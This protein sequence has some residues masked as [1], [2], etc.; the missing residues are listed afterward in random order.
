ME[1]QMPTLSNEIA[2]AASADDV[3]G[4][5]GDLRATPEWI[6]GVVEAE[7][8][9]RDRFCRTADGGEIRERITD[10]SDEQRSFSYEQRRVPLPIS[11]SKGTLRVVEDGDGSRVEWEAEFEAPAEVAAMVDGYYRQTLEALK[12][13]VETGARPG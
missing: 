2:I 10:R 4:I 5:L 12:L 1:V 13:R 8:S 3:W 11:G 7:V 6:P 9:G